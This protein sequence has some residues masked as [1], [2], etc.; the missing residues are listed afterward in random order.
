MELREVFLLLAWNGIKK[1]KIYIRKEENKK[2]TYIYKT[3]YN[4]GGALQCA[5][6]RCIN[7]NGN[8]S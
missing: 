5:N 8:V 7:L 2:K 3:L 4:N 6:S 1:N